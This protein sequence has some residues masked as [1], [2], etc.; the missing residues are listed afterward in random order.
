MRAKGLLAGSLL[1][2]KDKTGA[3]ALVKD[4]LAKDARNEQALILRAEMEIEEGQI[5]DAI[6]DLRT[7]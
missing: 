4:L 5:E 6:A 1:A 7:I 3:K 2:G